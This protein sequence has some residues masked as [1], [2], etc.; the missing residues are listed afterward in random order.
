MWN[1][2]IFTPFWRLVYSNPVAIP[3]YCS[4]IFSRTI[5]DYLPFNNYDILQNVPKDF[6]ALVASSTATVKIN[7]PNLQDNALA[8]VHQDGPDLKKG[9]LVQCVSKYV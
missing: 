7:A 4:E 8:T 1:W 9:N 3:A 5:H 6:M 2:A